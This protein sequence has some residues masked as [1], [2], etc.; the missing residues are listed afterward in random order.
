MS[1][2]RPRSAQAQSTSSETLPSKLSGQGLESSEQ[3]PEPTRQGLEGESWAEPVSCER[4]EAWIRRFASEG[5]LGTGLSR[6][7]RTLLRAHASGCEACDA[8][9]Q[10]VVGTLARLGN[11]RRTTRVARE[12]QERRERLRRNVFEAQTS[13]RWSHSRLRALAYPALICFLLVALGQRVLDSPGAK[14]LAQGPEVWLR[15]QVLRPDHGEASLRPGERL[16]SGSAGSAT[17][18]MGL[19]RWELG[20]ESEVRLESLR[21]T[22]LRLFQGQAQ[23]EGPF[24]AY[25]SEGLL[26]ASEVAHV[27]VHELETGWEVAVLAG[28][29]AWVTALGEATLESGTVWRAEEGRLQ[30]AVAPLPA[31]LP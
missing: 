2:S 23:I 6:Q 22:S 7:E 3:G 29:V 26:R 31:S 12:K 20:P 17:I 4:A 19:T 30:R 24:V 14:V 16:A 8:H 25:L 15:G 10:S 27:T 28:Q 1:H 9:Y 5:A 21:P 18:S 11:D 13:R